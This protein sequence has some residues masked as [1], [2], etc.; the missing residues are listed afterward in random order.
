M[1]GNRVLA[2][3]WNYFVAAAGGPRDDVVPGLY[4]V[5]HRIPARVP[6]TRNETTGGGEF[7]IQHETTRETAGNG[8]KRH[9]VD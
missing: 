4:L 1:V 9:G 3:N 6:I 7:T 2:F 5:S 8:R